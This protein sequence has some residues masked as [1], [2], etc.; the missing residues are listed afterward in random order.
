MTAGV[1]HRIDSDGR[2]IV[3]QND[4]FLADPD[5]S[6]FFARDIAEIESRVAVE[7]NRDGL[8]VLRLLE[9]QI[10]RRRGRLGSRTGKL[11]NQNGS[12]HRQYPQNYFAAQNLAAQLRVKIFLK[13]QL[14]QE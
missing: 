9:F 8:A 13:M 10:L 7:M 6:Q 2:L 4:Q 1:E 14:G 5:E 12:V 11:C 3:E